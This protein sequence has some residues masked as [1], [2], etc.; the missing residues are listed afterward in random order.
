[1]GNLSRR[2]GSLE[3]KQKTPARFEVLIT[4]DPVNDQEYLEKLQCANDRGVVVWTVVVVKP[5]THDHHL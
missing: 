3:G 5:D 2:I 1:M 4:N